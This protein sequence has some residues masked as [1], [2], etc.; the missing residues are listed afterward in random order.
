MTTS[1]PSDVVV[2]GAGVVGA[3]CAYFLARSG[4][5]VTLFERGG[6]AAGT[7]SAC[8]CIMGYGLYADDY[9]R[10][11]QS[12]AIRAYA[13]LLDEGFDLDY[14]RHGALVVP[15]GDGA[16]EILD[17]RAVAIRSAGFAPTW[18]EGSAL[19]EA[20]PELSHSHDRALLLPE[21]AQVSPMRVALELTQAAGRS[22][23]NIVTESTVSAI[24]VGA[25]GVK[26]VIVNGEAIAAE[27]VVLAAGVWSR[28]I[29]ATAGL[30]VPV[31]P[32]RGHVIATEPVPSLLHHEVVE[33]RPATKA[34]EERDSAIRDLPPIFAN[35]EE[36]PG[37]TLLLGGSR[38]VG[39]YD[40]NVDPRIVRAIL[41]RV[42]GLVPR[43]AEVRVVR[44][45]TGL[46]PWTPDGRPIVG[47]SV[48]VRGLAFA[49]GHGG[50]GITLSVVTGQLI[51]EL[52]SGRTTAL[53]LGPLSP[54]RFGI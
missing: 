51:G 54:Q 22:G 1:R 52:L 3:A 38:E 53:D 14:A 39:G 40:R 29:A 6:V 34:P 45:F 26:G 44:S 24:K 48:R 7:S 50:E 5:S 10:E 19:R 46:R 16:A 25:Q 32:V 27:S 21:I 31:F 41:E 15:T 11:L 9:E 36:L 49:T 43:V 18:I 35:V 17:E 2:I 4:L 42:V 28:D 20:E 33:F 13:H 23:A 37:G 30:D 8:T 47:H 12:A